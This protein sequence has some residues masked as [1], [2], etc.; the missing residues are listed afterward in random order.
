MGRTCNTHG[1]DENA[2]KILVGKTVGKRPLGRSSRRWE[3]NIG[4]NLMEVDWEGV[5]WIHLAHDR[6]QSQALAL[7]N[8]VMNLRV[9]FQAGNFLTS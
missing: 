9:P 2:L 1:K 6:D 3:D 8:M 7:V 5:D 4:K